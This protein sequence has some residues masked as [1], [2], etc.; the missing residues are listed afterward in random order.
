MAAIGCAGIL[1]SDLFCGPMPALPVEGELLA[2]PAMTNSAGG[3]AAN[4]AIDLAR[5]GLRVDVAGCVGTD[6]A[7][8]PLLAELARSG[9]GC[10]RIKRSTEFATSK[11]VILVVAHQDRRYIHTFGANAA[12]GAGDLDPE[13][14][15]GLDI[16]Y[17]GGLFAL[18]A[19]DARALAALLAAAR[20]AGTTT[21]VDVVVPNS[22][23]D[24]A[25]LD[26][27]LPHIDIFV[28]NADEARAFSGLDDPVEQIAALQARGARTTI[29][30]CGEHGAY[31]GS[32]GRCLHAPAHR[33][34]AI[35]P[36]GSG[37]AFTAGIIAGLAEGLDLPAMLRLGC[38][39]GASA[40]RAMGTTTSVFRR[41]EAV[42]FIAA[43]PIELKELEWKS[44]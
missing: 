13:W 36:S 20:A 6:P 42:A 43:N 1:V 3:C 31:A 25:A 12:F 11:T 9:V 26:L 18:P 33:L 44:R 34:D 17:L 4:V 19:M 14:L 38:A 27:L 21:V 37:D 29:V 32:D 23:G 24:N 5:Q 35:D 16:F 22:D 39:L 28:P 8:E 10:G 41:E 40:T 7:A 30:T 15:A 2:V